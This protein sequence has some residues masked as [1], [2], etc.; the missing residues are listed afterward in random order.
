[1]AGNTDNGEAPDFRSTPDYDFLRPSVSHSLIG[2]NTGTGLAEAQAA[3]A[4]G[5]L[6]GSSAAP[7]DPLLVPLAFNGGLMQ[8]HGLLPGSRAI[9]AG[10]NALAVNAAG[11]TLLYDQRG[12]GFDRFVSGTIDI[13]AF[14]FDPGATLEGP[15]VVT[16]TRDEGGVIERPDLLTTYSVT[17]DQDVNV[18]AGDLTVLNDSLVRAHVDLSAVVF[19]YDPQTQTATWDFTSLSLDPAF[20]LFELSD[21]IVSTDSGV[22]LDGNGDGIPGSNFVE[23]V[24]VAIPGDANLDGQVDVLGDAFAL[25]ANLGASGGATWAQGDFNGDGEVDVLGDAFILVSNL[26]QAATQLLV[27]GNSSDVVNGDTSSVPNLVASPGS[28]GISLREAIIASNNTLAPDFIHFDRNVLSGN[29]TSL[30]R[31]TDGELEITDSLTIDGSSA[32]DVTITGDA[33]GDDVTDADFITDVAAS[34]GGVAGVADDLLDDNSRVFNFTA[35]TGDLMLTG[36]TITGGRTTEDN[37]FIASSRET[38][39]SGAGIRF[40]SSGQFD[41]AASSVSGNSTEG[42]DASGGAIYTASGS[43]TLVESEV[44]D[45]STGGYFASGGGIATGSGT[46]S[47]TDSEVSGNSAK[48]QGGGISSISGDVTLNDSV[49]FGN[50]TD[51]IRSSYG[52]GINTVS[53]AITSVNSSVSSNLTTGFTSDGGG[54]HTNSGAITLTGSSVDGNST[55]GDSSNGGGIASVSGAV[56]LND[57]SVQGNSTTGDFA[58]GGGLH[59]RGPRAGE[60]PSLTLYRSTVSENSTSG[61]FSRG[62]GI[63]RELGP[64]VLVESTISANSTA[65][66]YAGGGGIFHGFS[67]LDVSSSTISGNSTAAD[68]SRGGGVHAGGPVMVTRSTISG[69]STTGLRSEGGGVF[70]TDELTLVS[71]T[72][73]DNFAGDEGGG[74]FSETE[75][76]TI[77]NSIVAGNIHNA[78]E[79]GGVPND[80]RR[81]L[82]VPVVVNHSLIGVVDTG[83]GV[84]TFS[85]DGLGN[86]TGTLANP[87]DPLLTPLAD[88][89]GPTLTHAPLPGSPVIDAGNSTETFDQRG[90][91]RVVD[92][93]F[94]VDSA[95]GNGS[96]IGAVEFQSLVLIV[97]TPDDELDAADTTLTSLDASD[98]SLREAIAITNDVSGTNG[99]TFDPSVFTGGTD[100]LIRLTGGQLEVTDAVTVAGSNVDDLTITGDANG[101]DVVDASFVTDVAAS[102]GGTAGATDDLLDDNSRV[103]IIGGTG[104]STLAGLTI[105]GGRTTESNRAEGGGILTAPLLFGQSASARQLT[106]LNSTIAGNS[107]A[108]SFSEGGGIFARSPLT[109]IQSTVSGNSTSGLSSD[110]GGVAFDFSDSSDSLVVTDSVIRGN[111]TTGDRADGGGIFSL[112]EVDLS[113]SIVRDNFTSGEDARGGGIFVGSRNLTIADTAV[114]GNYTLGDGAEGGGIFSNSANLTLNGSTVSNNFTSG[115]DAHGGGVFTDSSEVRLVN[116]TVSGNYVAGNS[117]RAGGIYARSSDIRLTNSTVAENSS[118]GAGGGLAIAG[119]FTFTSHTVTIENTIIADNVQNDVLGTAGTSDDIVIDNTDA[120]VTI[121]HSLIGA[122]DSI[123]QPIVGDVGN[124]FGTTASPLDPV[125]GPLADNGGATETHALLFSSPALD[126]GSNDL[127]LD[128]NGVALGN[129]QRGTG[130]DRIL[131]N[132]I[133]IGAFELDPSTLPNVPVVL[134]TVRDEGGVLERPDLLTTYTVTFDRDV[135]VDASDL[136]IVNDTVG[137]V[138][139]DLSAATFGY[140][141]STQTA[142]WGLSSIPLS[143]ALYSFVLSDDIVSTNGAVPLDGDGDGVLGGDF[144]ELVYVALPGDADLDGQV[145]VLADGFPLVANLG[146]TGGVPW[147]QGDFDDDGQVDV[148]GDAFILVA[149]LGRSV[150]PTATS[151]L[152]LAGS[153]AIDAAFED[154]DLLDVG[155]F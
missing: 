86:Q 136:S 76:L 125:V 80:I 131:G 153:Q 112:R 3:S 143:E 66:L 96:D 154:Q 97:T 43:I 85:I 27:V 72:V 129:D 94:I 102:F 54:I 142:T 99:I 47:L 151:S 149:N 12:T 134:D 21:E 7:I 113:G 58:S 61:D 91:A 105:T 127:A 108:G 74:I 116:T 26:G 109:L 121:N 4:S 67:A 90:L 106:I 144:T 31:L 13:G 35:N 147:L 88:N 115:A 24:Y 57:S 73:V 103:F 135:D 155:L 59:S 140:D 77:E 5:N 30:I 92:Q 78:S 71:S 141:S 44:S 34:F 68:G 50:S 98:L 148:L 133:D 120:V 137:G 18:E 70:T 29:L 128:E 82:A 56:T 20:Y 130:F 62:G 119:N 25:V 65:G 37:E 46:V 123:L 52:G 23:T 93:Q 28:D 19:D 150:I 69:N 45:N 36:L 14:E 60:G 75:S 104:D 145:D 6:V 53:G 83:P 111:S 22:P 55:T 64:V 122:A 17:F 51:G 40:V 48:H 107:T 139:V 110:G 8:T 87:L 81:L 38:T 15:V 152:A 79:A 42:A 1:M 124:L 89:G 32:I 10:N 11:S 100:S 126:A 114:S 33:D 41:I 63:N 132:S 95:T 101:D 146:T 39:H 49:I 2:D 84:A 9:D 117:A 118:A 138:T 16:T